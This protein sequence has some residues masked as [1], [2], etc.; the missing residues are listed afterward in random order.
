MNLKFFVAFF[1]WK[2]LLPHV[3]SRH[4]VRLCFLDCHV[5]Y[6]TANLDRLHRNENKQVEHIVFQCKHVIYY[7]SGGILIFITWIAF[8][9]INRE[10][11]EGI[12]SFDNYN[13]WIYEVLL[14]FNILQYYLSHKTNVRE[15]FVSETCWFSQATS[16]HHLLLSKQ[17]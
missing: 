3:K 14:H 10:I 1:Q 11:L 4:S 16:L 12:C 8:S 13:R 15:V 2:I 17:C 7:C 9:F 5:S 6:V